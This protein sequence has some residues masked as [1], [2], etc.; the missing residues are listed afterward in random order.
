M[1]WSPRE[2]TL[3]SRLQRDRRVIRHQ[4]RVHR[5]PTLSLPDAVELIIGPMARS[6]EPVD[7]GEYLQLDKLLASQAPK[8]AEAGAP[9]HDEMLFIV[10]HQAY[11]LW[12]KQI[13][14]ELDSVHEPLPPRLGGRAQR[15]RGGRPPRARRGDP[16]DPARPAP[17]AR[18]HD[19][20]RLP[21][22]P[23]PARARL[24]LPERAVPADRE[25]PRP[26]AARARAPRTLARRRRGSASG[27][28]ERAA[29]APKRSPRSS[30]LVE[31][32]LERTPFLEL[33]GFQF[34]EQY[35]AAV[36]R[37]LAAD[38]ATIEAQPHLVPRRARRAAPRAGA[39]RGELRGRDRREPPTR[40]FA[41]RANA[42]CLTGPPAPPS[43]S[44]STA[45]SRSCTCPS[46]CCT[47]WWTWT[48]CS[49]PGATGTPS[50]STA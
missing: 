5:P 13:L 32:W 27:Q 33:P 3:R 36:E 1:P 40:S 48:S 15:R 20:P 50:W 47:R 43:S 18:D 12:F 9:A 16:E 7:Y 6:H 25:P 26:A 14:H 31:R 22:V 35:D 4:L 39:D 19:A 2:I 21:G 30:T 45:T 44:T 8:S 28:R 38:R 17:G 37:M 10:V 34:W 41:R 29:R 24:R 11:E 46:A 23:R 42:A 49:R